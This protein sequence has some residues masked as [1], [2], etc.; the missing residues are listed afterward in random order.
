MRVTD[1]GTLLEQ[2][3]RRLVLPLPVV[4]YPSSMRMSPSS[5]LSPASRLMR[6]ASSSSRVAWSNW[7]ARL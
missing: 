2:P 7:P 4:E 5:A 3:E 1:A 6:K